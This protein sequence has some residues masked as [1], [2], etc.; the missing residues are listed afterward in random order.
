MTLPMRLPCTCNVRLFL[1]LVLSLVMACGDGVV[2]SHVIPGY[3]KLA[4]VN[5]QPLPYNAPPSLGQ[6]LGSIWR[7]DLVLRPDGTFAH[8]LGGGIGGLVEGRYRVAGNEIVF[9][10]DALYP[11][12]GTVARAS[13]DQLTFTYTEATDRTLRF[14]FHRA[15]LPPGLP[16]GGYRLTSID[17]RT[18]PPLVAYDT[19]FGTTRYVRQILF[20]SI[21]VTD[22]VFFR[23]HRL[24]RDSTYRDSG[25][26]GGEIEWSTWG[27]YEA[28]PGQVSLHH[29]RRPIPTLQ[30]DDTLS[31]AGDTL[32]RR[33]PASIIGPWEERYTR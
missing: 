11:G 18:S 3:Y 8:G 5:G 20:D 31:I 4:S 17:G 13:V 24:W 30:L 26:D 1:M 9:E 32:I 15:Q 28:V 29:Y 10:T 27:A 7:G 16:T 22:G 14:T 6:V 33:T 2:L 12:D 23:R 21:V 19:S 25:I